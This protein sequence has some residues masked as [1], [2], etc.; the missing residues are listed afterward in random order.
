M[1]RTAFNFESFIVYQRALSLSK[2][3]YILTQKWPKEYLFGLTDQLRR[4][5]LSIGLN[6]AE[7]SSRT[8]K[9]FRHF[10]I[11]A[12]GSSFE[13]IPLV[14][15]ALELQLVSLQEYDILYNELREISLMLSK[16]RSSLD[17]H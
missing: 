6:I 16:F 10:L 3:I 7:G 8:R 12:R 2:K 1:I 5:V 17:A 4:A 11:I 9:D 14:Q 13:C 15:L